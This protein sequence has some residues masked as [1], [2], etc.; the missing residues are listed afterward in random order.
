MIS[1]VR[2]RNDGLQNIKIL[3]KNLNNKRRI[4]HK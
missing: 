1:I 2:K 4:S 3:S